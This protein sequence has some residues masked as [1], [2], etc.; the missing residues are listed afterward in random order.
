[1]AYA[2]A[3]VSYS[4]PV[5][6]NMGPRLSMEQYWAV[7]ALKAETLLSSRVEHHEELRQIAYSEESKRSV[8]EQAYFPDVQV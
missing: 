8:S 1:M 2:T 3:T 4:N 6:Q 7:R 5:T